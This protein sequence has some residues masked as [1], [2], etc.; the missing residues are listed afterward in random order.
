M[1]RP[2]SSQAHASASF[3]WLGAVAVV[4]LGFSTAGI[5]LG[6]RSLVLSTDAARRAVA[7][8]GTIFSSC[9]L[10]PSMLRATVPWVAMG[11][12]LCGLLRG[13]RN[14]WRTIRANR[15]FLAALR[16]QPMD[17][18]PLLRR[19]A[20][21]I[22]LLRWI[23]LIDRP[24]RPEAFTAGLATPHIYVTR[25]LCA[26]LAPQELT[27]VLLHENHHRQ[28]R[29]PLRALVILFLQ[30]LLFFLPVG[31]VL[32]RVFFEAGEHAAD[33]AVGARGG[34]SLELASALCRLAKLEFAGPRAGSLARITGRGSIQRRVER[35]LSP[36]RDE[37][38]PP[39]V[40]GLLGSALTG[41]LLV[42]SLYLPILMGGSPFEFQGCTGAY[43][44]S[45][46]CGKG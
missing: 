5:A 31:Y 3:W 21:E 22:G 40:A 44:Q 36:H 42:T 10:S 39:R 6:M 19:A 7:C 32:G 27:A 12:L 8:C 43:C 26:V 18:V 11:I 17:R 33:D 25:E 9:L 15:S 46:E 38:A 20:Q 41:A 35:L 16:E 34:D 13:L 37:L 29:D 45:V 28:S 23:R 4:F 2:R 14:G 1:R 30:D 24:G